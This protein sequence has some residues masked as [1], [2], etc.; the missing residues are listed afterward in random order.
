MTSDFNSR[1]M[2]LG[3]SHESLD[4]VIILPRCEDFLSTLVCSAV[5]ELPVLLKNQVFF[6]F[7][8]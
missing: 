7:R 2:S 5:N 1:L 4:Q 6:F 3:M 8:F